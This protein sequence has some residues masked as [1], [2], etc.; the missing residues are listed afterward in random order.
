MREQV[1]NG[2]S[3]RTVWLVEID[4]ALLGG[5]QR[6]E[7]GDQLRHRSEANRARRITVGGNS[8]ARFDDASGRE[9]DG[10]AVD[11]AKYLH[12]RRY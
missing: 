2:R 12:A 11:L 3:R 5:N 9:V 4:D 10:P 6:S 1:A 7:R 8:P